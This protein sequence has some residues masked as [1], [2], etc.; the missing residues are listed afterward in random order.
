MNFKTILACGLLTV[1]AMGSTAFGT[2]LSP[3]NVGSTI[4]YPYDSGSKSWTDNGGFSVSSTDLATS[5]TLSMDAAHPQ[6][7][8]G[9]LRT[10]TDGGKYG[11][12][13]PGNTEESA[14]P[15]NG[16]VMTMTFNTG[17][18]GSA[19]GYDISSIISTTGYTVNRV[20][21]NYDVRAHLVSGTWVDLCTTNGSVGEYTSYD[22]SWMATEEVQVTFNN[23]GSAMV[24]GVAALEFTFHD[25][26][27]SGYANGAPEAVYREIDVLGTATATPEPGTIILLTTALTGL[28]AYA[29]RKRR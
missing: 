3:T 9:A 8:F 4:W 11:G 14:L 19:T 5:A 24:T 28:L 26:S 27:N 7:L 13:Y 25:S 16:C 20:S 2:H 12:A 29:W 1:L 22:P 23:A 15:L 21:Q 6:L 17:A 10:L 18:G